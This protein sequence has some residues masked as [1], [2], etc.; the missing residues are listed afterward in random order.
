ML[1][2]YMTREQGRSGKGGLSPETWTL[3]PGASMDLNEEVSH[4][5]SQQVTNQIMLM[6]HRTTE[7]TQYP[8]RS[9]VSQAEHQQG[10][11]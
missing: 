4:I 11:G 1:W 3:A 10:P 5:H 2:I 8:P 6:A 7:F 9:I